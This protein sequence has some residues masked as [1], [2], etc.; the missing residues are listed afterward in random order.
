MVLKYDKPFIRGYNSILCIEE[1]SNTTQMDFGVL[2]LD[3]DRTYEDC[4]KK[5]KAYLL[6]KGK[7]LFKWGNETREVS[8][9]SFLDENPCCLHVPAGVGIQVVSLHD[10]TEISVSRTYNDK[11]FAPRFYSREDC[12]TE[13]AG[14]GK[15][16]EAALR[17]IRTIFDISNTPDANLVLGEVVHMPGR[18]SSYPPHHHPQPEVYFYKFQP[19]QGFG[20]SQVG[21][22][23]YKVQNNDTCV[24]ANGGDHPQVAAPG[25][26]MFYVWVIRNL[27][28][29]PFNER[30]YSDEHKWLFE[31]DVKIWPECGGAL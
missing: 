31:K 28:G 15:F 22:E 4:E 20:Y 19:K 27:D 1:S 21:D 23:V 11:Y 9:E 30:I 25:Y 24:I 3:K 5:E 16:G 18:W 14:K 6:L 2:L 13:E 12:L 17:K 29:N 8:R 26:A 7:V 10:N